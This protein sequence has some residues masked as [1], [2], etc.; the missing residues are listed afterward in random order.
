MFERE[1]TEGVRPIL[2]LPEVLLG[3]LAA[4]DGCNVDEEDNGGVAGVLDFATP[5]TLAFMRVD[6]TV[7]CKSDSWLEI[8]DE[9]GEK[10]LLRAEERPE[11]CDIDD[12]L[13]CLTRR[14]QFY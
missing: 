4:E 7:G 10:R 1:E 6:D 14:K 12:I 5:D 8:T 3:E 13:A 2:W 11:T 9:G